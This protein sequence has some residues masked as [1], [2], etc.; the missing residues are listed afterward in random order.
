MDN[1]IMSNNIF[2]TLSTLSVPLKVALADELT[3]YLAAPVER[4]CDPLLWWVKRHTLYPCLS[5]MACDYLC[6][7]G[8][9][10]LLGTQCIQSNP[11]S[12]AM[13]IDVKR[14]FSKG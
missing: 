9:F 5:W 10:V 8:M 2:D 4:T 3:H 14:L 6:I 13:S 1:T 11:Y 12:S 7:P